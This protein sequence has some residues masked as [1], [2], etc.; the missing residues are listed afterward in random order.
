MT[1]EELKLTLKE[2]EL[3]YEEDKLEGILNDIN[4]IKDDSD[5]DPA[6]FIRDIE[7]RLSKIKHEIDTTI[8]LIDVV[9]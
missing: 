7:E 4:K 6:L 9:E 1:M 2:M 5:F 8:S 3:D